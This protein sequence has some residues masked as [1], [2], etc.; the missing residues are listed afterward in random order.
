MSQI[1][2]NSLMRLISRALDSFREHLFRRPGVA[3]VRGESGTASLGTKTGTSLQLATE[4]DIQIAFRTAF[5]G[6][7][8]TACSNHGCFRIQIRLPQLGC[9]S[10]K[11]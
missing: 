4:G 9:G 8:R 5:R 2:G 11:Y 3:L 6:A 7:G 10:G 1:C